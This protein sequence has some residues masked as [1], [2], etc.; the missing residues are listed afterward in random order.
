MGF[1]KKIAQKVK[2][3]AS[4]KNVIG[5]ATG[6]YLGVAK[7]ALRVATTNK[8]VK[9]VGQ[10]TVMTPDATFVSPQTQIPRIVQDTLLAKGAKQSSKMVNLLAQNKDVQSVAN[11]T[12]AFMSKVYLQAMWLKHKTLILV[13][14]GGLV[15]FLVYWFGFRA[16]NTKRRGR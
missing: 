8:L 13:I 7:D 11:Q 9:S 5:L 4:L 12:S 2:R 1:F 6:N 15:A 10:P 3:V 16:K 14:G